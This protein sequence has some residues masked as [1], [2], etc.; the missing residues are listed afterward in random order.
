MQRLDN[1]IT[2][3]ELLNKLDTDTYVQNE[4][5]NDNSSH[6]KKFKIRQDIIRK[7]IRKEDVGT[8]HMI[9]EFEDDKNNSRFLCFDGKEIV[10]AI[11]VFTN[12]QLEITL[13]NF[14]YR[15]DTLPSKLKLD[16]LDAEINTILHSDKAVKIEKE[17]DDLL[18]TWVEN[19]R[20]KII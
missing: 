7:L 10:N 9:D 4:E 11:V 12:D 5:D 16:F 3:S 17:I 2:V 15:Y 1:E 19:A 14:N 8:I 13:D 20:H 18:M 6:F